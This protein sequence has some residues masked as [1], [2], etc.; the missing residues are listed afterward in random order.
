MMFE[1]ITAAHIRAWGQPSFGDEHLICGFAGYSLDGKMAA[2]FCAYPIGDK[3]WVGFDRN[4]HC[5]RSVH[6]QIVRSLDALASVEI[7]GG[8]GVAPLDRAPNVLIR[9]NGE[10]ATINGVRLVFYHWAP[11]H[12]SGDLMIYLPDEKVMVAGDILFS[13]GRAN[14]GS[15]KFE[16]DGSP[17]GWFKNV[18]GMLSTDAELFVTGHGRQLMT[19]AEVQQ[20]LDDFRIKMAKVDALAASGKSLAETVAA[21]GDPPFD[22]MA[23][24][25]KDPYTIKECPRAIRAM[26]DSW[27]RWHEWTYENKI[28]NKMAAK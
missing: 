16:K 18:E 26:T 2:L 7:D 3:W 27:I 21:M 10:T 28:L 5:T 15:F 11:G 17:A 6:K 4:E 25:I 19:R 24:T 20:R 9:Q 12:T 8:Y 14:G 23:N 22:P 13:S 1:D